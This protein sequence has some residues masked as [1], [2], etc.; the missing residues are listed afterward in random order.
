LAHKT[1]RKK[2]SQPRDCASI[3]QVKKE[4]NRQSPTS[5]SG[6]GERKRE[7]ENTEQPGKP[8]HQIGDQ[9]KKRSLSFEREEKER[10][11]TM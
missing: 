1:G 11:Q 9:Q 4:G 8:T 3:F 2:E 10:P 7:K 5:N 6:T